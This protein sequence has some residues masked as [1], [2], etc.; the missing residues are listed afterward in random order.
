M[1]FRIRDKSL[2]WTKSGWK[3]NWE[4]KI[5]N[6]PKPCNPVET[7]FV[8]TKKDHH[9]FLRS[10]SV[11]IQWCKLTET[12]PESTNNTFMVTRNW[13]KLC[14]LSSEASS[15]CLSIARPQFS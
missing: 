6:M 10:T 4:P 13:N 3:N 2:F 9:S 12:T 11:V 14:K 8:T 5:L 7:A 1:V 15:I